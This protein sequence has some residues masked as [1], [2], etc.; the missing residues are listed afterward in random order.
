MT[1]EKH[2]DQ[3]A[4]GL[5]RKVDGGKIPKEWKIWTWKQYYDDCSRFAKTLIHLNIDRFS[6]VN[7]LGFNSVSY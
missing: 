7:I 1:C 3:I 4:L 2:G 5:K 6:I